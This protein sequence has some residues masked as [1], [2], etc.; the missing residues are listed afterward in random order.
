MHAFNAG[1][2]EQLQQHQPMVTRMAYHMVSRLPASVD[3]DDLIQV[4]MIGLSDAISRCKP[5][6]GELERFA[7]FRIRGA[8]I[9]ELRGLDWVPRQYRKS[10]RE[11]EL[12][13]QRLQN[14]LCRRP[15]DTE[16]AAELGIPLADVQHEMGKVYRAQLVQLDDMDLLNAEGDD[17][18]EGSGASGPSLGNWHADPL[19]LLEAGRR[20]NALADAIRALPSRV[21][22]VIVL[23]YSGDMSFREIGGQFGLSESRVCQLHRRAVELLRASLHNH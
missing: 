16:L 12:A 19:S 23:H 3:V 7:K 22:E 18:R 11:I 10:G 21:R 14:Q 8:M 13:V 4:G 20:Q 5:G 2:D 15:T 1:H 6:E 9:D 17:D